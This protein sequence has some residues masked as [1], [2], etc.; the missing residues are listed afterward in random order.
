LRKWGNED[1][2]KGGLQFILLQFRKKVELG[3]KKE[4]E[5]VLKPNKNRHLT[6]KRK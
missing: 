3:N 4:K 6:N 2:R 5:S 1:L